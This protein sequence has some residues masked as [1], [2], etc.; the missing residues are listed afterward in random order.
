MPSER[1]TV[2]AIGRPSRRCSINIPLLDAEVPA[3]A[4]FCGMQEEGCLRKVRASLATIGPIVESRAALSARI[5]S[6]DGYD[7]FL[8]PF[9]PRLDA[10]FP[11]YQVLTRDLTSHAYAFVR[12]DVEAALTGV[13]R[14][15]SIARNLVASG[16]TLI[17]SM[18]G[19]ALMK[20]SG[21]LLIEMLAELPA[22]H[23][24]PDRCRQVFV[25]DGA[26]EAGI[27]S[28]MMGEGRYSTGSLRAFD[29]D[30]SVR[31][32]TECNLEDQSW[33]WG[34]LFFD[35]KKTA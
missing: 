23:P 3:D 5:A 26:M 28:A 17:G 15:A 16:D 8:S 13:C 10:P 2:S 1:G 11:A 18:I 30:A 32:L 21:A 19:V 6:L 7:Y 35:P 34:Q 12:S 27:C 31:I 22:N 9:P 29:A 25:P 33:Y 4:S 24:L 14:T 20:G